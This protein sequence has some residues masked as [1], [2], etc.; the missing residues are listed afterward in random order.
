M[1]YS[2]VALD[3]LQSPYIKRIKPFQVAF[4]HV[5]GD[6]IPESNEFLLR[7]VLGNFVVHADISE[8]LASSTPPNSMNILQWVL[9]SL[10]V[11][12]LHTPNTNTLDAQTL[13]LHTPQTQF[14]KFDTNHKNYTNTC[15][16]KWQGAWI[17]LSKV[18]GSSIVNEKNRR[19]KSL[20]PLNW[21]FDM[22][23]SESN[24]IFRYQSSQTNK[25]I[26]ITSLLIKLKTLP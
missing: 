25:I 13:N 5:F 17:P 22:D 14:P 7:E 1:P 16:S 23:Y 19:R 15:S 12:N 3:L 4:N 2:S 10:V 9:D 26:K 6:F 21:S 20:A 11:R 18:W 24:V 8:N